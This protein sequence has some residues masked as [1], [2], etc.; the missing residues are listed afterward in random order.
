VALGSGPARRAIDRAAWRTERF[1][2]AR[3]FDPQ[4]NRARRR[5]GIRVV[6]DSFFT[7]VD[8]GQPHLVMASPAVVDRPADWPQNVTLTGFVTWTAAAHSRIAT[9]WRS[10]SPPVTHPS[11]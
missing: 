10:S 6:S 9:A 2:L 5:L 4:V 1:N 11:W 7:P 3:V 8:S